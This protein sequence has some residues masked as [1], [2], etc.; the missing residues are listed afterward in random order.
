[1]DGVVQD[2]RYAIRLARDFALWREAIES[3]GAG[4]GLNFAHRR[5]PACQ[6]HPG[7]ACGQG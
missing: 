1:M 4:V 2:L 6:L 5:G 7:A 3:R